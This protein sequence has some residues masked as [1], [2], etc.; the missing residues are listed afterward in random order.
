VLG[1]GRLA[2][3]HR[4]DEILDVAIQIAD[5]LDAAH[6]EGILHRDITPANTF[7]T[8]RGHAKLLD[9]G[10]AKLLPEQKAGPG[11]VQ[12]S[13]LTTETADELLTS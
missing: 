3:R 2:C 5:S 11:A 9:F 8:K 4:T 13:D 7:V 1:H 6:S 10:L 12:A